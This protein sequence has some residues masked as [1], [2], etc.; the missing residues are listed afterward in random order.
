MLFVLDIYIVVL[1][2]LYVALR[3]ILI[4]VEFVWVGVQSHNLVS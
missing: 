4:K 1:V 2:T 3:L